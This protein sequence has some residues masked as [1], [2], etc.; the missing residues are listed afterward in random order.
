MMTSG[1][2]ASAESVGDIPSS[3]GMTSGRSRNRKYIIGGVSLVIVV[4][5]IVLSVVLTSGGGGGGD[6]NNSNSN[7]SGNGSG[8]G[9]GSGSGNGSAGSPS[10]GDILNAD[11][12]RSS[13]DTALRAEGV[14]STAAWDDPASYQAQ[15]LSWL[16]TDS[17]GK[18]HHQDRIHQRYAMAAFY[19]AT[20]GAVTAY[21]PDGLPWNDNTGWLSDQHEC[22]W[23]G[24]ICSEFFKVTGISLSENEVAGSLPMELVLIK[25]HLQTL[26]FSENKIYMSGAQLDVFGKLKK[27]KKIVMPDNYVL[28]D[29]GLP[30]AMGECT[31]LEQ[32]ELSYNLLEGPISGALLSRWT[33]LTH[34]EVES[35]YL[36]GSLPAELGFMSELVYLYLRRNSFNT[37]LDFLHSGNMDNLCK[38]HPVCD[39][40]PSSTCQSP[41][42]P[43]G[44]MNTC[45]HTRM[46]SLTLSLPHPLFQSPLALFWILFHSF[47]VARR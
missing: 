38:Y 12:F 18:N 8:S 27:L 15:A 34:L 21:S 6:T 16:T 14:T 30:S 20:N 40:I 25:D 13:I 47:H 1:K 28:T 26:D 37:N 46:L 42:Q 2:E 24:V 7:G 10:S 22:S 5:V 29:N 36:S 44:R 35:N 17:D 4:V 3:P 23:T 9:S 19:F 32:L 41:H 11:T 43:I 31:D 33:K 45:V 39:A